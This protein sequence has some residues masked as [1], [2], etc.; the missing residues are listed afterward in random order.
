ME[1]VATRPVT[2][3]GMP[4]RPGDR[5]TGL[6]AGRASQLVAH[7]ILRDVSDKSRDFV[8]IRDFQVRGKQYTK[9]QKVRITKLPQVKLH[10]LLEHRYLEPTV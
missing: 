7:R 2:I 8:V 9:G 10:Q 5:V 1:V 3:G 4:Y 6:S